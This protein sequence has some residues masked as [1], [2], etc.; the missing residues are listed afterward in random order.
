MLKSEEF[1]DFLDRQRL[2]DFLKNEKPILEDVMDYRTY[3]CG[4]AKPSAKT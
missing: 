4:I 3:C 1:R 2:S